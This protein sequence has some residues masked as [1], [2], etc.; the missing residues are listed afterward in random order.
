L[1]EHWTLTFIGRYYF[2]AAIFNKVV[3]IGL[4][5]SK[6]ASKQA[7]RNLYV[8]KVCALFRDR[9]PLLKITGPEDPFHPS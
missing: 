4:Q 3:L 8:D 2:A 9:Y 6:Q 5:A 1:S 7:S